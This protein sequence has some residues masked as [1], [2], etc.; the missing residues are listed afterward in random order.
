RTCLPY[1]YLLCLPI[2]SPAF[3][4]LFPY[5]TL[6]RS[7]FGKGV[8]ATEG[9]FGSSAPLPEATR[10]ELFAYVESE[11]LAIVDLLPDTNDYG[12]ANR[13][14][15]HTSELQSR[16]NLVCRLLPEK[17]NEMLIKR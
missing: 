1:R 7:T 15:E 17:K 6:F 10:A 2:D 5:S 16:E 8:W 11:L 4:V 3:Y 9:N 13:S 12:R 14:E